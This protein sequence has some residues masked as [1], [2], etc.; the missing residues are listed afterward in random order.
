MVNC[1]TSGK[2][3][4]LPRL[5]HFHLMSRLSRQIAPLSRRSRPRYALFLPRHGVC[6]S[7][8]LLTFDDLQT[9]ES[10]LPGSSAY[11]YH[12]ETSASFVAKRPTSSSSA[13]QRTQ[14]ARSVGRFEPYGI[15]PHEGYAG[16][17]L[18]A[19]VSASADQPSGYWSAPTAPIS[20]QASGPIHTSGYDAYYTHSGPPL[21]TSQPP[22]SSGRSSFQ[23]VRPFG[24]LPEGPVRQPSY[25]NRS[26]ESS[27]FNYQR[28]RTAASDTYDHSAPYETTFARPFDTRPGTGSKSAH[29]GLSAHSL[30]HLNDH[31]ARY[32][33]QDRHALPPHSQISPPRPTSSSS[34]ASHA[35]P[36]TA[37][38]SGQEQPRSVPFDQSWA[39]QPGKASFPVQDTGFHQ[40]ESPSYPH[41][42]MPF[43]PLGSFASY[44][45]PAASGLVMAIPTYH[46]DHSRPSTSHSPSISPVATYAGMP[47]P[48]NHH[49][50]GMPPSPRSRQPE[51]RAWQAAQRE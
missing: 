11:P 19:S 22:S 34:S 23:P 7:K 37:P 6:I 13:G 27:I 41:T 2:V 24:S 25:E 47:A 20:S 49:A 21:V 45:R 39:P 26:N 14:M 8:Q 35:R 33:P 12:A 46:H 5:R 9:Y 29:W 1:V 10:Q 51:S 40:S 48:G 3:Q 31:G 42:D 4:T 18:S 30:G 16:R 50:N 17:P 43:A 28:P 38:W 15:R 36:P 44:K 32:P